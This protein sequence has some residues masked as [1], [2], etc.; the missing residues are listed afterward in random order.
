M[1]H[2]HGGRH[3]WTGTGCNAA[4]WDQPASREPGSGSTIMSYSSICGADNV[5]GSQVGNLYFHADSRERIVGYTGAGGGTVCGVAAATGNAVPSVNGGADYTIPRGTPFVLTASGSDADDPGAALSY[6]WEQYDVASARAPLNAVDDGVIPLL[7]SFPPSSS[8]ARTFP[9]FADL[10]AG[11]PSLFPNKL[12]EQLPSTD[13]G[14]SFRVTVRDNRPNIGAAD[15][16][17]VQLTVSGAPFVVDAP[18]GINPLECAVSD[19]V[20]WTVGGGSVAPTVDIRLSTNGGASFPTLLASATA[21]DGSEAVNVPATLSGSAR[22][23]IDSVGNVFFNLSGPTAIFD[24]L[25]PTPSCPLDVTVE[26][27]DPGGTPMGDPSLAAFFAGV[28]ATDAC[29]ASPSLTNDAP[30][31]FPVG[32]TPVSFTAT[33]DSGNADSCSADVTVEDSVPPTIAVSVSPTELWPPNHKLATITA[34]VVLADVCDPNVAFELVSVTSDEPDNGL[35]D[36][37]TTGDVQGAALGTPDLSFELRA[38]RSGKGDGRVYTVVYRAFDM[39]GNS[40]Q[41]AA[42]VVVPKSRGK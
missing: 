5:L 14:L 24:T 12:G 40:A 25:D 32:T 20:Q 33:D 2:Q 27:T 7:R 8:A 3:T 37:D 30:P 29:D 41:A 39:S 19:T 38:E 35:G 18:S 11:A 28:S 9:R 15:D 4:Q 10:L 21:N 22:V 23:R 36:G 26:C 16:D 17:A 13:R 42:Q 34:S 6:V 31:L 1:G